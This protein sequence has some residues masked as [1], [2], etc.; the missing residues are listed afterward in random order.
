MQRFE[1]AITAFQ[2]AVA[3]FQNTGERHREGV[4]LGNLA[5]ALL[6]V[7]RPAE[8]IVAYQDA[9]VIFRDTGDQHHEGMAL[10]NL[11]VAR[12]VRQD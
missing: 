11:E 10:E 5:N 2:S 12:A 4:A 6:Q 3:I 1:E 8:A 9:S 7:G